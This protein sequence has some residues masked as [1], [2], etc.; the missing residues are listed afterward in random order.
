MI[1][2]V[3]FNTTHDGYTPI[4]EGAA[5]FGSSSG[6]AYDSLNVGATTFAGAPYA[7]VDLAPDLAHIAIGVGVLQVGPGWLLYKPL[8]EVI[9]AP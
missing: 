7:G 3:A 4:G 2:T 8:G 6:C 9:T 1:W 5:C